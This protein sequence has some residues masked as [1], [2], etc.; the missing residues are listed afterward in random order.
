MHQ[1]LQ[2]PA[3]LCQCPLLLFFFLYASKPKHGLL[4]FLTDFKTVPTKPSQ[5]A[6]V[7]GQSSKSTSLQHFSNGHHHH[8]TLSFTHILGLATFGSPPSYLRS[9]NLTLQP[10]PL[11]FRLYVSCMS[12]TLHSLPCP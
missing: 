12:H 3:N 2:G 11:V 1:P 7:H 4:V 10:C 8:H 6:T 5:C 9:I